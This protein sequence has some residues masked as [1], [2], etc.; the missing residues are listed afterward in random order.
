MSAQSAAANPH[1]LTGCRVR[2]VGR[3]GGV[4]FV[5]MGSFEGLSQDASADFYVVTFTLEDEQ[6]VPPRR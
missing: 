2:E 1:H 6:W 4:A 5:L 3:A